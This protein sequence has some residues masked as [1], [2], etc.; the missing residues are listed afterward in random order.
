MGR[1]ERRKA[2]RAGRVGFDAAF[3]AVVAV[4]AKGGAKGWARGFGGIVGLGLVY[5]FVVV[6]E[7]VVMSEV[8]RSDRRS[9][10]VRGLKAKYTTA[11]LWRTRD[12]SN[13]SELQAWV[14]K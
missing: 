1:W 6:G 7:W 4:A 9:I 5:R 2:E 11:F 3:G 14:L 13:N 8:D 12:K 10:D